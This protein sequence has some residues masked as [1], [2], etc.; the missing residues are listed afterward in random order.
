[1]VGKWRQSSSNTGADFL[2]GGYAK[3]LVTFRADGI[4]EI[5]RMFDEAGEVSLT[6]RIGYSWNKSMSK[7]TLGSDPAD[8]PKQGSLKGFTIDES[9]VKALDA[10][11][12]LPLVIRCRRLKNGMIMLGDKTYSPVK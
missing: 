11:D 7:L 5:Q 1:V 8:R 3:S 2:L 9:N 6:W 12:T 10:T 4:L